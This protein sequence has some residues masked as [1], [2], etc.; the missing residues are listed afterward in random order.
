M[1]MGKTEMGWFRYA[2]GYLPKY[3]TDIARL[4]RGPKRFIAQRHAG[5]VDALGDSLMFLVY[6][7]AIVVAMSASHLPPGASVGL[8]FAREALAALLAVALFAVALR[9]G[10][11]LVGGKSTTRSFFVAYAYFFGATSVVLSFFVFVSN[12]LLRVLE[13]KIFAELWRLRGDSAADEL[14]RELAEIGLFESPVA[15]ASGLVIMAGLFM[16]AI[17]DFICWGAF[18]HLNEL[19]RIRSF[20]AMMITAPLILIASVVVLLVHAAMQPMSSAAGHVPAS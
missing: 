3:L 11:G 10:W 16:V 5:A 2:L 20:A 12:G 8:Y 18:R 19:S 17:W 13:P 9:V 15:V 6:S 7:L 14:L 1:V 4:L